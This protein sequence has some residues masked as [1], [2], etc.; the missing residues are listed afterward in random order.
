VNGLGDAPQLNSIPSKWING[1]GTQ[2]IS[3]HGINTDNQETQLN[4]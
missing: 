4:I 1:E 2:T 3:E